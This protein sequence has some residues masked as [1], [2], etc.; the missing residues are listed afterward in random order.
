MVRSSSA[1]RPLVVSRLA[2]AL[3][4]AHERQLERAN[5]LFE[6]LLRGA[7]AYAEAWFEFGQLLHEQGKLE[8]AA[9]CYERA[10]E[11]QPA[12]TRAA[13]KHAEILEHLGQLEHARRLLVSVLE[14]APD[15][16]Q[17]L[18]Q[19]GS[20]LKRLGLPRAGLACFQR[21]RA[22]D[23]RSM[24][25]ELGQLGTLLEL[26]ELELVAQLLT[27]GALAKD[28]AQ[29]HFLEAELAYYRGE[30]ARAKTDYEQSLFYDPNRAAAH[31][32][33]GRCLLLEGDFERGLEEYEW[34]RE[35]ERT[36]QLPSL[37]IYRG[38]D[39]GGKHLLVSFEGSPADAILYA[40]FLPILT[41]RAQ[42]VYFECPRSLLRF[43]AL[44]H[45]M[46]AL[47][48]CGDVL[49]SV[50]YQLPLFN[51]PRMARRLART[52]GADE[53]FWL[54]G[55]LAIE[56]PPELL[57]SDRLEQTLGLKPSPELRV[58]LAWA[59]DDAQP[60]NASQNCPAE[61][62]SQLAGVP[63]TRFFSLQRGP[64]AEEVSALGGLVVPLPVMA[65]DVAALVG[66]IQCLD[67]V[68]SVDS[69]L[70]HVA[71]ACGRPT[72]GLLAA[73][74]DG[75]WHLPSGQGW[76]PRLRLFQQTRPGD[77]HEP[78]QELRAELAKLTGLEPAN[79]PY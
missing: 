27:A 48:A 21:A 22:L 51:L 70:L 77:W 59:N 29:R 9:E 69:A 52:S 16:P 75:R 64:A 35:L 15:H 25:A 28:H 6:N 23:S 58:G 3:H 50:D 32:G 78:V 20:C 34:R 8:R 12:H 7:P 24:A 10:R 66:A 11:L 54:S 14:E 42:A 4:A 63:R 56:F 71:G 5:E 76:Y 43:F 57:R 38:G 45:E 68:I 33:L 72:W 31:Y 1:A 60:T 47:V 40:R 49:P 65:D 26:G 79:T 61:L 13:L 55:P 17:I 41:A 73:P 19:L 44:M 18:I 37:P 62:L 46:P 53:Q 39:L 2:Q 36:R 67:L 74:A 30:Y